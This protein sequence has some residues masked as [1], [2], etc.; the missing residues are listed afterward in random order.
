M[1]RRLPRLPS[2]IFICSLAP[3]LKRSGGFSGNARRLTRLRPR[4]S[5]KNELA[6]AGSAR[7]LDHPIFS[8]H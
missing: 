4:S 7:A 6:L 8:T 3:I 2:R 5:G 1:K